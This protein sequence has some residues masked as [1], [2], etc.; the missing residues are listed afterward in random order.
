[1]N[2]SVQLTIFISKQLLDNQTLVQRIHLRIQKVHETRLKRRTHQL[3][4]YNRCTSR[5]Q[6]VLQYKR[7]KQRAQYAWGITIT[8]NEGGQPPANASGNARMSQKPAGSIQGQE[9]M[10]HEF[11]IRH[12]PPARSAADGDPVHDEFESSDILQVSRKGALLQKLCYTQRQVTFY[13]NLFF[14][15][16]ILH[17]A[18]PIHLQVSRSPSSLPPSRSTCLPYSAMFTPP[19]PPSD[20]PKHCLVGTAPIFNQTCPRATC[21]ST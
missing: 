20:R 7:G 17:T 16:F 1:V 11:K 13:I 15:V 18:F 4:A 2:D 9:A 8:N 21:F 19:P 14:P 12:R 10:R 6:H 3:Q 5:E